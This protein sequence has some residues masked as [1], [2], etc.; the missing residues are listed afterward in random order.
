MRI[1]MM[2]SV[3]ESPICAPWR[4]GLDICLV[5]PFVSRQ[6]AQY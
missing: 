6:R 2:P 1:F 3:D 5:E 4:H